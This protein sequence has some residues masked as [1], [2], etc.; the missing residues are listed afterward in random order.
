MSAIARPIAEAGLL[1]GCRVAFTGRLATLTRSA[2]HSLVR[3]H[4]G[5]VVRSVTRRTGM[6]VIGMRGWPILPNG[7]VSS[8]LERAE[9]LTAVGHRL[10]ILSEA[11]F[12]E[13]IGLDPP[14]S[15][16][17]KTYTAGQIAELLGIDPLQLRRWEQLSLVRSEGGHYDFRDLV[18]LR[19]IASLVSRGV[20]TDV[21]A[22]SL[23]RFGR[24]LP[25]SERP[26][27][28]LRLVAEDPSSVLVECDGA[29]I[30]PDGQLR[31][32]FG[33][34]DEPPPAPRPRLEPGDPADDALQRGLECEEAGDLPAAMAA[35]REAL[36]K[37]PDFAEAAFN[38]G[39]VLR[40]HG[41]IGEAEQAY[42]RAVELD[43][44][45]AE[46]WYNLADMAERR[47]ALA[48]SVQHLEAALRIDPDYADAHYNLARCLEALARE[49]EAARHWSSYLRLDPSSDWA[50][51]ARRQ[52]QRIRDGA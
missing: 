45:L 19:T 48:A 5:T 50:D 3:Q 14:A 38:L 30:G 18:S 24:F 40:T 51:A 13:R 35:Y 42:R 11:A 25:D 28:Q 21:I 43:P 23:R 44:G 6:L 41:D 10:E 4:G 27:A 22:E 8:L 7:A 26:L 2:A 16:Q 29:L 33:Q 32:D 17:A 52:L 49:G 34:T 1:Q 46:G 36:Q 37:Q 31:M 15:T 9:E 39:N 12:R 47:G 20:R